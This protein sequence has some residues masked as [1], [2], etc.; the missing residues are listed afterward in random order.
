MAKKTRQIAGSGAGAAAS[1]PAAP[2][3]VLRPDPPGTPITRHALH[4]LARQLGLEG[5]DRIAA[6]IVGDELHLTLTPLAMA[7]GRLAAETV[8]MVLCIAD[9][10][11]TYFPDD[12]HTT[13][14]DCGTL[15][16]H[17]PHVPRRPKKVC[18]DCGSRPAAAAEGGDDHTA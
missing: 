2:T 7:E 8:D 14:A 6:T 11:P 9:E 12:V 5:D 1:W 4:D 17:R 3:F 16:R 18:L 10:G 13:C 15:I